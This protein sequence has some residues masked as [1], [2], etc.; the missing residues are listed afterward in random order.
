MLGFRSKCGSVST[1]VFLVRTFRSIF[2]PL[3]IKSLRLVI[4]FTRIFSYFRACNL[5]SL[6]GL[7]S[8]ESDVSDKTKKYE[9]IQFVCFLDMGCGAVCFVNHECKHT[10]RCDTNIP[11][12]CLETI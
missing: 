2:R 7:E 8:V 4:V 3:A 5:S 9:P 10:D 1:R 6:S 11:V 12:Q